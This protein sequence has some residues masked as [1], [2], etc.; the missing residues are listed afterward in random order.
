MVGL[1]FVGNFV[2]F[3]VGLLFLLFVGTFVATFA[4][5]VGLLFDG[6]FVLLFD[7]DFVGTF[8]CWYFWYFCMII[9]W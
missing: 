7:A 1:L 4:L 8:V 2:G 5:L 6:D 9:C 3:L